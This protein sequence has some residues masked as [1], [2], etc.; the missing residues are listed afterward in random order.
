MTTYGKFLSVL[1]SDQKIIIIY[2]YIYIYISKGLKIPNNLKSL[3][4]F[5]NKLETTHVNSDIHKC[6]NEGI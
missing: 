1:R 6:K 5:L 2:L 3:L 4:F